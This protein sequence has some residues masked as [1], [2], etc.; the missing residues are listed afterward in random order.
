MGSLLSVSTITSFRTLNFAEVPPSLLTIRQNTLFNQWGGG[1]EVLTSA[2]T[3]EAIKSSINRY[4]S[5][6]TFPFL[7]QV[8]PICPP[9]MQ[10]IY[11][12]L[13]KTSPVATGT[14]AEYTG[15]PNL[16]SGFLGS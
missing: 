1:A 5:I 12:L 14:I 7:G 16:Q 2:A 11:L 4:L 6:G 3:G 13:Q 8:S 10:R 9:G 15:R